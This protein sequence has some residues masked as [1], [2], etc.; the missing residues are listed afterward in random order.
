[1]L[2]SKAV[3]ATEGDKHTNYFLNLEKYKQDTNQIK[4]LFNKNGEVVNDTYSIL[5]IEYNVYKD[6][7][8]SVQIEIDKI[9]ELS[10]T[11]K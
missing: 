8:S 7:Y 10:K 2:R 9:D 4:E 6:L 3:W 1:M 5:D 11:C